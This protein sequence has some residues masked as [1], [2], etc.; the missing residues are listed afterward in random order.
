MAISRNRFGP[1]KAEQEMTDPVFSVPLVEVPMPSTA[2]ITNG[3]GRLKM[4]FSRNRLGPRNSERKGRGWQ[5]GPVIHT[6]LHPPLYKMTAEPA[7]MHHFYLEPHTT[8]TLQINRGSY[9]M[10]LSKAALFALLLVGLVAVGSCLSPAKPAGPY[11]PPPPPRPNYHPRLRRTVDYLVDYQP[12]IVEGAR[13]KRL[14]PP[15][16]V[17]PLPPPPPSPP[18]A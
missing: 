1:M 17:V 7:K 18:M 5:N 12:E 15:I 10:A 16:V 4:A 13:Y 6:G 11:R 8:H 2:S 9:K 14:S 3:L